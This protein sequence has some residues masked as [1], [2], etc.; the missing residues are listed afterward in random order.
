LLK[1]S[2]VGI[3]TLSISGSAAGLS[4]FLPAGDFDPQN[5]DAA[6]VFEFKF[7]QSQV[8]SVRSPRMASLF[9]A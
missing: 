8:I 6:L 1:V 2:I 5:H 4:L 7:W 9:A 3:A